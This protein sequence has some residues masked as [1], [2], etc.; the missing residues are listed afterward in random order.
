MPFM[1]GHNL[2]SDG[3]NLTSNNLSVAYVV[4][5]LSNRTEGILLDVAEQVLAHER[6]GRG[7]K[8]IAMSLFGDNPRYVQ[9]ALHNAFLAQRDWPDWTLRFYYGD[10][11]PEKDLH[12]LRTLGAD[13]VKVDL[14]QNP[15]VSMY[16][17]FFA[18][19]D[20]TATRMISRDADAQL[21]LRDRAAVRE[22]IDSGHF[23]HTMHDHDQHPVPVLGG[24]WGSVNGFINPQI[25]H[26]WR[27]SKDQSSA[28]WGNDQD[29]LAKV[30]WPL[31][32]N[33]TLDH[34]SY[35][36]NS[37]GARE[38]RGFPTQRLHPYDFVGNAYRPEDSFKGTTAPAVC[39]TQCRRQPDWTSC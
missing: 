4:P 9:G 22:W 8:V 1:L 27:Q 10:G 39:P 12:I 29:W 5:D 38:W 20:R 36:C 14:A 6:A 35:F 19:E 7:Q 17:R 28:V 2:T 11:V 24:M 13:L 26:A 15:R 18:L 3:P 21:S 30:V 16:W 31:V 34:S 37:F 32:K 25:M 23:F 33:N